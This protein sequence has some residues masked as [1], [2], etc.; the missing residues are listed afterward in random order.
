MCATVILSNVITNICSYH[1]SKSISKDPPLPDIIL[2]LCGYKGVFE[3]SLS[4]VYWIWLVISFSSCLLAIVISKQKRLKKILKVMNVI[5]ITHLTRLT[6][7]PVTYFPSS[8]SAMNEFANKGSNF[9]NWNLG[10]IIAG[11][12]MSQSVIFSTISLCFFI[13]YHVDK[14]SGKIISILKFVETTALSVFMLHLKLHYT[15]DFLVTAS[16]TILTW[17]AYDQF[18]HL[19]KAKYSKQA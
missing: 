8:G 18:C 16:I 17:I 12:F 2:N 1:A 9:F 11:V 7:I 13:Q 10:K 6:I 15:V 4:T 14:L 19:Y 5:T 3:S